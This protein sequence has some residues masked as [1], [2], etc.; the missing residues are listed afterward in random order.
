MNKYK[1]FTRHGQKIAVKQG[2]SWPAFLFTGFWA[3]SKGMAGLGVLGV[4][5]YWP[6]AWLIAGIIFGSKGNNWWEN[7]LLKSGFTLAGSVQ[8][9]GTKEAVLK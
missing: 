5:L 1:I 8:A 6:P 2:W 7:K 4:V 3:F 9:S